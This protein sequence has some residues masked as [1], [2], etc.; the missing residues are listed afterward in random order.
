MLLVT[1]EE[2]TM[3]YAIRLPLRNDFTEQHKKLRSIQGKTKRLHREPTLQLLEETAGV[4]PKK[5]QK[6]ILFSLAKIQTPQGK[7]LAPDQDETPSCRSH[8]RQ[9]PSCGSRGARIPQP[10]PFR[11]AL[12]SCSSRA[13]AGARGRARRTPW[14][15]LHSPRGQQTLVGA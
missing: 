15:R 1:G 12:R 4:F 5:A 8:T 10:T 3:L 11:A 9:K 14:H 6:E 7:R 2:E 13:R